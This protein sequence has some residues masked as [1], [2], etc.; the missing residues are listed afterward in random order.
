[1][2]R[3]IPETRSRTVRWRF[4]PDLAGEAAGALADLVESAVRAGDEAFSQIRHEEE[5]GAWWGRLPGGEGDLFVKARLIGVPRQR[6]ASL[7]IPRGLRRE[8]VQSLWFQAR[9]LPCAEPLALGELRS[10]GMLH[11]SLFVARWV[12]DG[13]CLADVAAVADDQT[14]NELICLAG[15]LLGRLFSEGVIHRQFHPWNLLLVP[16]T[17]TGSRL[18]PVDLQH[19]WISG[20]LTD[21]DLLWALDQV[22][23]WLHDPVIDWRDEALATRFYTAALDAAAEAVDDLDRVRDQAAAFSRRGRSA[24][25][26]HRHQWAPPPHRGKP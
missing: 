11:T 19:A 6:L 10:F 26:L 21:D 16:G 15:G 7:V 2:T 12:T 23:F 25:K 24:V 20:K 8:W 4:A 13:R 9:S 22:S 14:Q 17:G 3:R 1:V 18:L 5:R